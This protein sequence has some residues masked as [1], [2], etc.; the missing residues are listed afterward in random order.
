[1]SD[2]FENKGAMAATVVVAATNSL[3]VNAANYFCQAGIADDVVIQAALTAAAGGE[4][5]LLDGDY[6]ITANLTVPAD[7]K[8]RGMGKDT[9]LTGSGA[10]AGITQL[11]TLNDR[12]TLSDMKLILSAGCGTGGARPNVVY[13]NSKTLIWLEN[14]WIVGDIS[15]GND[16]SDI[17]QCGILFYT[18]TESKIIDCRSEDNYKHGIQLYWASNN[19]TVTGNTCQGN[20]LYAISLQA[21]SNNNTVTGNTCQANGTGIELQAGSNEN[22]VTGNMCEGSTYYGI[23]VHANTGGNT[24]TGNTCQGNGCDGIYLLDCSNNTVTGNTCIANGT[25]GTKYSGICIRSSNENVV[26]GN[27]CNSNGLHGI[28][29]YRSSYCA[30]TGNTCANQETADGINVTGDGT[31]NADYNTLTGNVC[32]GN[33]DDGIEIAGAGYA[34]KNIVVANQLLGNSGTALVDGGTNTEIGHNVTV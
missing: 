27:R 33:G 14:L 25:G 34:N 17:L 6:L 4:V 9:I 13:A 24:V 21:T 23:V 5:V 32:T 2:I 1:M 3:N 12:C 31:T 29:I 10:A 20:G 26:T 11:V 19:N 30:I 28:Y 22:V 16:G 15:V 8:L 18:V 7:T